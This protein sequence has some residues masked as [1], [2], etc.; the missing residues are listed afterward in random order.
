MKVAQVWDIEKAFLNIDVDPAD[1]SCL[2][3]LWLNDITAYDPETIVLAFN[4]VRFGV[5]SSPYL[6]NAVLRHHLSSFEDDD[7]AF[8]KG[9]PPLGGKSRVIQL[10][11]LHACAAAG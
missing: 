5:D 11:R 9:E 1:R 3:F 4:R 8:V 10:F 6:L 7:P 2:R